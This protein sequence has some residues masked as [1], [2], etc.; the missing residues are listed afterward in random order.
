MK[1]SIGSPLLLAGRVIRLQLPLLLRH[2]YCERPE[3]TDLAARCLINE[4]LR[5]PRCQRPCAH[6]PN[7][8]RR[9]SAVPVIEAHVGRRR[10]A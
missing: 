8:K 4:A 9:A 6:G 7:L 1:E 3:L 5:N 10:I 2:F